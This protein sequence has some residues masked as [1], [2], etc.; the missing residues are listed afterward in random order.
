MFRGTSFHTIDV[1]GR[2]IIPARFRDVAKAGGGDGVMVTRMDNALFA[3]S[4]DEW[5]KIEE[6]VL[7]VP[8]T[9]NAMRRFRRIFI[10]GASECNCDKQGRILI[11][12]SLRLYAGLEKEITLVGQITHFEIWSKG[13]YELE[14]KTLNEDLNNEEVSNQIAKLRL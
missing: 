12:P 5:S 13:N 3:Y 7:S 6:R 8:E 2:L 9:S 4:F 1:K 10:G 11:P 14:E